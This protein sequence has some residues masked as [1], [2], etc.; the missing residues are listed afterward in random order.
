MPADPDPRD[1]AAAWRPQRPG[2]VAPR[3]LRDPI[4]EPDWGGLRAVAALTPG[5]A[6]IY[7]DGGEVPAPPD[8]LRALAEAFD[9]SDVVDAVIEGHLTKAAFDEGTVVFPTTPRV[10]RPLLAV[11]KAFRRSAK[12]DPYIHGRDHHRRAEME[13]PEVLTALR[14]GEPHA[15]VAIDLLWLDGQALLDVPLLERKRLLETVLVPSEL[16]RVTPYVRPTNALTL[17]TWGSQGFA[18]LSWRAANSRYLAGRENPGWVVVR[19]PDAASR[20]APGGMS[21]G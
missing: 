8:L 16:V 5:S 11:P 9:A 12:D 7:R 13:A 21:R 4:V 14:M 18:E 17:V 20:V 10:E 1:V 19:A 3:D 6:V 2:R 15:F